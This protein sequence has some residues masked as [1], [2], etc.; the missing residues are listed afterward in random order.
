MFGNVAYRG[1]FYKL[2]RIKMIL[3]SKF[4]FQEK[5]VLEI[6]IDYLPNEDRKSRQQANLES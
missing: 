1:V 4:D 6:M 3:D 2:K 5:G